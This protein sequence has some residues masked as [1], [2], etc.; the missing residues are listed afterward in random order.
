MQRLKQATDKA[1]A[2]LGRNIEEKIITIMRRN[3]R[4]TFMKDMVNALDPRDKGE[5]K[6]AL[7]KVLYEM[8][9][10]GK[11]KRTDSN[12]P[13]WTMVPQKKEIKSDCLYLEIRRSD[14]EVYACIQCH[15][16]NTGG[17]EVMLDTRSSTGILSVQRHS[18]KTSVGMDSIH[19]K[20]RLAV[21][22]LPWSGIYLPIDEDFEYINSSQEFDLDP[23][24]MQLYAWKLTEN[25]TKGWAYIQ[26]NNGT[27]PMVLG[28]D[29]EAE[30]EGALTRPPVAEINSDRVMI[31]KPAT[32]HEWQYLLIMI[33]HACTKCVFKE[34]WFIIGETVEQLMQSVYRETSGDDQ[35][36]YRSVP[37]PREYSNITKSGMPSSR[38]EPV[39]KNFVD[40]RTPKEKLDAAVLSLTKLD[41]KGVET[42][43]DAGLHK[44]AVLECIGK[45]GQ[46]NPKEGTRETYR[47]NE[48]GFFVCMLAVELG[49]GVV[50]YGQGTAPRKKTSM[51]MAYKKVYDR[52]L[53]RRDEAIE[54]I[55]SDGSFARVQPLASWKNAGSTLESIIELGDAATSSRYTPD[56]VPFAIRRQNSKYIEILREYMSTFYEAEPPEEI[57]MYIQAEVD[58]HLDVLKSGRYGSGYNVEEEMKGILGKIITATIDCGGSVSKMFVRNAQIK[59]WLGV[60]IP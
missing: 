32:F 2:Y 49:N 25:R 38:I 15:I 52:L 14:K 27:E 53:A 18:R 59:S 31:W 12:P 40:T 10:Q 9:S 8:Q 23:N 35:G 20:E 26:R 30:L 13:L 6:R 5:T 45:A 28:D 41:L 36:D 60:E 47:R 24:H 17:P 4:G 46:K 43:L 55:K 19:N 42:P 11:V 44:S 51:Q 21:F 50:E 48:R 57:S 1:M 37:V 34:D 29:L 16:F 7:N 33:K 56:M 39:N 3:A 58:S 54:R 22:R